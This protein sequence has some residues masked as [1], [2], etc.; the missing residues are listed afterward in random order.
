VRVAFFLLAIVPGVA[1]C[2][3]AQ[4]GDNPAALIVAD[5]TRFTVL[6]PAQAETAVQQ[7]SRPAPEIEGAWALSAEDAAAV[8]RR[9]PDLLREPPARFPAGARVDLAASHRQYVGVVVGGRRL[10]YVNAFPASILR[11]GWHR[12]GEALIVCDGGAAFWGA[13][14]DPATGR[15]S[16][17]AFN[18]EA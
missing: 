14:Y 17:L 18:G 9:L 6:D 13:L 7:C 1:G 12:P 16:G 3:G 11:E 5:T 10:V 2:G 15:F 8:E 4:A